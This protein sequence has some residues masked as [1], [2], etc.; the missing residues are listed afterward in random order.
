LIIGI[1]LDNT[2]IDY[3]DSFWLT[4][5]ST[6]II[7]EDDKKDFSFKKDIS[8]SKAQIK[9]YLKSNKNSDFMWESLQG[10]VYG[11][12]MHNAKIFPG[13]ANFLLHCKT[14]GVKVFIVSHKTKFGHN[15]S[16]R[17]PLR[18]TALN[19]LRENNFLSNDYG[20]N[21]NNIFFFNTRK[22]K[23]NKIA[24]L[25]C[26]YFIDDL[27][28][29]FEEVNFP[30]KTTK[31]LFEPESEK[32]M[33]DTF[34]S[35]WRINENIFNK[36]RNSDISAYVEIAIKDKV[37]LVQ[38]VKGRGNSNIYKID[39]KSGKVF[40]GKLYPDK[41]FDKRDRIIKET[42][43]YNFLHLKKINKVPKSISSDSNLNF[44]LF[45]WIYGQEVT[46]IT[47]AHINEV[48]DFVIKLANI[49]RNTAPET[50]GLASAACLSGEMIEKQIYER[51]NILQKLAKS[52]PDLSDFLN[53]N[54]YQ[55]I[56]KILRISKKKWPGNYKKILEGE[57]R[58]L[59]PSDFGFHN[60]IQTKKGLKFIDFE[61]FGWDDPVKL[62]CDFLLHPAMALTQSQKLIWFKKMN[63]IFSYDSNFTARLSA[64]YC[65]YGLCWCLIIL[66][67]FTKE[68]V[69][70]EKQDI[71]LSKSKRLLNYIL[72]LNE[73]GIMYA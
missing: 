14:R 23:V 50:F 6:G 32:L 36:I 66:N 40:V 45:E 71:R 51:Y 1:D 62:V 53:N 31:I 18:E 54:F 10:Q 44:A 61:Y 26:T 21:E 30:Q 37:K 39:M 43:A 9:H 70:K 19:F 64:S 58:I 2:I 63:E 20:I 47:D 41:T 4:A 12:Y 59:S 24:N 22:A 68:N 33:I 35:W 29:V 49:S 3:R 7:S 67:V 46:E 13:F 60:I 27:P 48:S 15:D 72:G 8:P 25:N 56:E 16:S 17:T 52:N 57:Y 65:L 42:S 73:K 55:A 28:Q 11:K 5:I 34:N 69:N 38:N